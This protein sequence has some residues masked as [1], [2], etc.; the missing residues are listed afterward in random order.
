MTVLSRADTDL[1]GIVRLSPGV[2]PAAAAVEPT[3]T[4]T[5]TSNRRA[6][7]RTRV[8]QSVVL[9]VMLVA[10]Y[11][12]YSLFVTNLWYQSR[13]RSLQNQA[14]S[15]SVISPKPGQYAGLLQLCNDASAACP[16]PSAFSL[17]LAVVQGDTPAQLREGPGHRPGTPL[18]G[19][20]GNSVIYGHDREWGA[21]F[22]NLHNIEK[23]SRLFV[24][25]RSGGQVVAYD[26]IGVHRVHDSQLARYLGPSNDY[27]LTLITDARGRLSG[28][29]LV[30]I[31]VSGTVGTQK[32]ASPGTDPDPAS[33][34]F[35]G[36]GIPNLVDWAL[37][38]VLMVVLLRRRYGP[39]TVAALATPVI[40]AA[41]LSGFVGLDLLWSP[42]A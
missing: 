3:D 38:G 8:S 11:A 30:V 25:P 37:G 4:A 21:P 1:E 36:T 33:G 13:Q 5:G 29:R 20:K 17:N 7:F 16:Q 19:A 28:E 2:A 12:F 22:G 42:L 18:P 34:S 40:A 15:A 10:A 6:K 24:E 39:L 32:P 31:A 26:V 35:S 9:G 41:L 23:G 14:V 27:R